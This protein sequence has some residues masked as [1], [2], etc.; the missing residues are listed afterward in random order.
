MLTA[1]AVYLLRI[2]TH[3]SSVPRWLWGEFGLTSNY[4]PVPSDA[5]SRTMMSTGTN[6]SSNSG[7]NSN[8]RLDTGRIVPVPL[9]LGLSECID[10][11]RLPVDD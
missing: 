5:T 6:G 3:P 8:Q 2:L 9:R 4:N 11:I 7:G 1:L 10:N